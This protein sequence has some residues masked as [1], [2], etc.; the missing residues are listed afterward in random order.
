MFED[1]IVKT[2]EDEKYDIIKVTHNVGSVDIK[3]SYVRGEIIAR[4]FERV[5]KAMGI[6]M[7]VKFELINNPEGIENKWAFCLALEAEKAGGLK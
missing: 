3:E 7:N 4:G 2:K 6:P 5:L 1:I